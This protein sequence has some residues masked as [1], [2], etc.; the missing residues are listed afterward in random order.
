M[1][2]RALIYVLKLKNERYYVG[3]TT[4]YEQD[5]YDHYVGIKSHFTERFEVVD[6]VGMYF[7]IE[8]TDEKYIIKQLI[9][10]YNKDKD[11]KNKDGKD[12]IYG[13]NYNIYPN[14]KEGSKVKIPYIDPEVAALLGVELFRNQL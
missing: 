10:K 2:H 7:E 1:K 5:I 14:D 4:D 11:D 8:K 12:K 6:V 9:E 13:Q 3:R